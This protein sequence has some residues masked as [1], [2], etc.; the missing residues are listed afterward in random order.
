MRSKAGESVLS[1]CHSIR[2]IPWQGGLDIKG[3]QAGGYQLTAEVTVGISP[4]IERS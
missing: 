2:A 1:A 4:P 3:F